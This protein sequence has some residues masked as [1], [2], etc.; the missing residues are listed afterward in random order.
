[1]CGTRVDAA[2]PSPSPYGQPQQ[3]YGQPPAPYPQPPP[4]YAAP[5]GP[6]PSKGMAMVGGITAIV[7]S[8]IYLLFGLIAVIA[9]AADSDPDA[10][11]AVAGGLIILVF[12]LSGVIF[13][14]FAVKARWWGCMVGGILQSVLALLLLLALAGLQQAEKEAGFAAELARDELDTAKTVILVWLLITAVVAVFNFIGIAS[15]KNYERGNSRSHLRA[16]DQF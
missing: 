16:A 6:P 13:G 1:M 9:G 5:A 7:I 15:A 12:G 11:G 4:Q 14:V 3:P 2:A 8:S 10:E